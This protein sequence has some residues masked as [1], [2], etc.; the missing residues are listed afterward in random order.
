MSRRQPDATPALRTIDRPVRAAAAT[1]HIRHAANARLSAIA[2]RFQSPVLHARYLLGVT[3]PPE[4]LLWAFN[5]R[6]I[7]ALRHGQQCAQLAGDVC[8]VGRLFDDHG[9]HHR[10]HARH[11]FGASDPRRGVG[12]WVC[13]HIVCCP[14]NEAPAIASTDGWGVQS[15]CAAAA[16]IARP[17]V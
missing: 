12:R 7:V 17:A 4:Y 8:A 6:K 2:G 10:E 13:G 11:R 5:M 3:R 9:S 1:R 14:H 15:D 16:S